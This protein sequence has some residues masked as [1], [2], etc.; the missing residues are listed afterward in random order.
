MS[1]I[2]LVGFPQ[3]TLTNDILNLI[4]VSGQS[5]EILHPHQFLSNNF[6]RTDKFLVTVTKDLDL[7]K[8][9]IS[10]LDQEN[11]ERATYIHHFAV[12]DQ[13]AVIGPG[14][15]V[16]PFASV[17]NNATI[18]KDCII[19]PYC[20]ISHNAE[21]GQGSILHPGAMI[22]GTTK[23]GKYCL[24]GLRST[25]IDKIEICDNV[26][27]GASSFITKPITVAGT[28]VGTPARKVA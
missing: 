6:N 7:R 3:A 10:K 17:F 18:G 16:G 26:V 28:Y 14:T 9:L 23:I 8:Q 20:M 24:F 13:Q 15:F 12:V 22:A 4:L 1:K 21:I 19:A 27:V 25:V 5:A 11:L 2:I